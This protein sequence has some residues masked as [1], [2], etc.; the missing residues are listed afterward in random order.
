MPTE[1]TINVDVEREVQTEQLEDVDFKQL[2][3]EARRRAEADA[4]ASS[5]D[6]D[7]GAA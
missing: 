3:K 1:L 7:F 5:V 2:R 4:K 6:L